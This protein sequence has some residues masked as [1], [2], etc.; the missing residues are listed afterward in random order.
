MAKWLQSNEIP[1]DEI[2]H[3]SSYPWAEGK[4][5]G[6]VYLDDRGVRFEGRW[7]TAYQRVQEL[8]HLEGLNVIAY[9]DED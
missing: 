5:V 8:L 3:N 1:Y 6:D 7:D 9:Q 4:P 2:N